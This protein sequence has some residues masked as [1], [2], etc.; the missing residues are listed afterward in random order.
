[1]TFRD[2]LEKRIA[3][4]QS[5]LCVGLDIRADKAGDEMKQMMIRVIEE[6]F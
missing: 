1:M 6:T 4:T 2:K 3:A 5:N